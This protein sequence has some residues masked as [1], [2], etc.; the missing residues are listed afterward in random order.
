MSILEFSYMGLVAMLRDN[1]CIRTL[2]AHIVFEDEKFEHNIAENKITHIP[3]YANSEQEH[4]KRKVIGCYSRATLP[5]GDVSYEFMPMW[6]IE[7]VKSMSVGSGSKYSAWNTWKDEMIK[8]S[9]IKRHFKLLISTDTTEALHT[10]LQIENDNNQLTNSF[11]KNNKRN[12]MTGFIDLEDDIKE[13]PTLFVD[14]TLEP[15]KE[16]KIAPMDISDNELE[17][18]MTIEAEKI[19]L[20]DTLDVFKQDY[21]IKPKITDEIK[22][23]ELDDLFNSKKKE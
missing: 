16:D 2:S 17:A 5:T 9:V 21:S 12:L 14:N 1:G 19:G 13:Q 11:N 3:T 8:K 4:N 6:E 15:I 23:K 22:D 7:K 10:A 18:L 20:D